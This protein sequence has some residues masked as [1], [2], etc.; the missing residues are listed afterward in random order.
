MRR[1][2]W[3]ACVLSAFALP[4]GMSGVAAAADLT[5]KDVQRALRAAWKDN[6]RCF[7]ASLCNSY[8]DT[9]GVGLLFA[10][11]SARPFAHVQRG[12]ASARDCI[13]S[14]KNAL[15][16]GDR[17]L[18][19]QWAMATQPAPSMREWMRENPDAVIESLRNCC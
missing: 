1:V 11:G 10:D 3:L 18:A 5:V 17:A 4:M 6:N 15:A 14:A 12:L 16:T 7:E 2:G 13:R 9:F 8:F 19:V